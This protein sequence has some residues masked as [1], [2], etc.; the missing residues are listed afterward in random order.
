MLFRSKANERGYETRRI[1]YKIEDIQKQQREAEQRMLNRANKAQGQA[2][3][4]QKSLADQMANKA[5]IADQI[6]GKMKDLKEVLDP[7]QA[8]ALK[9]QIND[10]VKQ[11]KDI[12]I[13]VDDQ[14]LLDSLNIEVTGEKLQETL[15]QAIESIK[16]DWRSEEHTSEL[17]SH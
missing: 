11:F 3:K 16:V 2:I 17:Q 9:T 12:K 15:T 5:K 7:K 14:A 6:I 13:T 4:T 8:S 10:L 1:G